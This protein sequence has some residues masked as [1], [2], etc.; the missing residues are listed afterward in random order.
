M[1]SGSL[2]EAS[3]LLGQP[4][5]GNQEGTVSAVLDSELTHNISD[6]R[7]RVRYSR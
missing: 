7:H 6:R 3:G 4:T 1:Y 2:P 5:F